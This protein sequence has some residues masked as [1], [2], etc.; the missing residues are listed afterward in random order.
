MRMRALW[1]LLALFAITGTFVGCQSTGG[2]QEGGCS[3]CGQ[4]HGPADSQR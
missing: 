3:N 2:Y 4:N 1:T